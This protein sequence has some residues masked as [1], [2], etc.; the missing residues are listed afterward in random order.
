MLLLGGLGGAGLASLWMHTPA[1]PSTPILH[2]QQ[3]GAAAIA[4]P[5]MSLGVV[6]APAVTAPTA[7]AGAGAPTYDPREELSTLEAAFALYAQGKC[8]A[9]RAKLGK[10]TGRVHAKDYS[11]LRAKIDACLAKDGGTP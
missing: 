6:S 5:T 11:E 10:R 9:A 3:P 2:E 4:P 1:E 8:E 7:S